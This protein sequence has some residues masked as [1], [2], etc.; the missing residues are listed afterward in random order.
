MN[1]DIRS[2]TTA[3]IAAALFVG[4][5]A[6]TAGPSGAIFTTNDVGTWV[7]GNVYPA[8]DAVYLNGG[9]RVNQKCTAAGLPEGDY[10]FQV[11]DPSG[12]LLLSD[13]AL[14][15]RKIHVSG[16]VIT[17]YL[18][19]THVTGTVAGHCGGQTVQLA[20]FDDTLNPGGE[21][22]VWLTP[23]VP[24]CDEDFPV[25]DGAFHPRD[26]KTDNFKV[27]APDPDPDPDG[28]GD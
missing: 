24:G 20:P 10:Y 1:R 18:G 16:G 11:T 7:N 5:T 26:S 14:S 2:I 15:E 6:A 21:Y 17:L 19:S 23:A 9:P 22:K 12:E 25:C 4:A 27:Q 28:D 3:G 13:D 8:K